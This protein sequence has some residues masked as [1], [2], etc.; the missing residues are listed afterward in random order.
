[1]FFQN[2][3]KRRHC[4]YLKGHMTRFLALVFTSQVTQSTE[5][6]TV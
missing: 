3:V 6:N 4:A 1:L 5:S 2:T